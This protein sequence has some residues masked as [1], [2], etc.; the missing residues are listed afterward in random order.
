[1]ILPVV[2]AGN[3][4]VFLL[5]PWISPNTFKIFLQKG[6][7][8]HSLFHFHC[9]SP[10]ITPSSFL[11]SDRWK[12]HKQLLRFLLVPFIQL[13]CLIF[14]N[15]NSS[16]VPYYLITSPLGIAYKRKSGLFYVELKCSIIWP[17][18]LF[19]L[20]SHFLDMLTTPGT[21]VNSRPFMVKCLCLHDF[22]LQ[23]VNSLTCSV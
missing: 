2:W 22:L 20:L 5:S 18:S 15:Y 21:I 14:A 11:K 13:A 17:N 23:P 4:S 10:D 3:L 16:H 9:S 12:R 7:H 1:M 19:I 8:F 6:S